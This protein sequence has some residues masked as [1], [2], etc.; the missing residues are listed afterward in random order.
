MWG[1]FRGQIREDQENQWM[2]KEVTKWENE[3]FD[4]LHKKKSIME[5][6]CWFGLKFL[7]ASEM[8]IGEVQN[9]HPIS[10]RNLQNH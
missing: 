2:L 6:H 7:Y 1:R 10:G 4:L 5:V 8:E 3:N 9:V